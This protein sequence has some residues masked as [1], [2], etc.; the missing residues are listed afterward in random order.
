M[1]IKKIWANII[2]L[3]LSS[4]ACL[5]GGTSTNEIIIF[6]TPLKLFPTITPSPQRHTPTATKTP[7]PS[8]TPRVWPSP[9]FGS[10]GPTQITPIPPPA[11]TFLDIESINFLL[12]GADRKTSSFR[13]DVLILVNFQPEHNAINLISIPRD[14]YVYI[15]G[16]TMQRINAAYQHGESSSFP[17]TG[18]QLLGDTI[19]YNLGIEI[20]FFALVDFDGFINIVDILGGIEVPI[21]C[22]YTDWRVIDPEEDIQDEENWELFTVGPG[23]V[24]MDGDLALWYARS[25]KKSSDFDRGRR[26]QELLRSIYAQALQLKMISKIPQLYQEMN[27]SI[28][29]NM[30]LN[31]TLAISPLI[32]NISSAQIRSYYINNSLVTGWRSPQ[33]ASL[34]LPKHSAI[35][36]MLKEALNPPNLSE[37]DNLSANIEIWNGTSN[38]EWDILAAERLAYGG[39]LSQIGISDR[40]NYSKTIL[41]DFTEKQNNDKSSELLSALGLSE[42]NLIHSPNPDNVVSYL[43]V[44][45]N[46]YK[47]CFNPSQFQQ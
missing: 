29:T 1:R 42:S 46:D 15:P 3:I 14:L 39:Y 7:I 17:G 37:N 34:L 31:D 35:Q 44:I 6:P 5:F 2:L 25:R 16:W 12:I 21:T 24:E 11:P 13:T 45:G 20:D 22:A 9:Y 28:K 30:S 27:A 38:S 19:M 43:L 33:G 41:F 10:P 26:Q 36:N 23:A 47:P 8:P 18:P 40:H 32:A 4:V